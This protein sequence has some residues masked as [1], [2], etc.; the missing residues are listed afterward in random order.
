MQGDHRRRQQAQPFERRPVGSVRPSCGYIGSGTSRSTSAAI[1]MPMKKDAVAA[2]PAKGP[3]SVLKAC[4][5]CGISSTSETYTMTPAENPRL[6]ARNRGAGCG[7]RNVRRPPT[8]VASPAVRLSPNA[9]PIS[10]TQACWMERAPPSSLR[11]SP[12]S[13]A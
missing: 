1:P 12:G 9:N 3:N 7:M 6:P 5:D 2:Q 13:G 8:P 11:A 10:D 4:Y